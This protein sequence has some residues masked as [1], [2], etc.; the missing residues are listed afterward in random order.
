MG[1]SLSL[2]CWQAAAEVARVPMR[3]PVTG[4]FRP[5]E[6]DY[7]EKTGAS[8][9]EAF[10]Q[11]LGRDLPAPLFVAAQRW[12]SAFPA[13]RGFPHIR[14]RGARFLKPLSSFLGLRRRGPQ[15]DRIVRE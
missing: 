5:Q 2:S 3:D 14:R 8:L 13:P 11:Q 12:G 6:R 9:V 10:A 15:V 4:A 7:L 1:L